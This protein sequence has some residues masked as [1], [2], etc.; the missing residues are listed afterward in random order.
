MEPTSYT[1]PLW[2]PYI[3][4]KITSNIVVGVLGNANHNVDNEAS[5]LI[6]AGFF[7]LIFVFFFYIYTSLVYVAATGNGRCGN[8]VYTL[9]KSLYDLRRCV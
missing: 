2:P 4:M 7:L 9:P 5:F 1:E 6:V 3:L 8:V